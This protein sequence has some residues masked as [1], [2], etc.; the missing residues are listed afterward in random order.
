MDGP[1]A[2]W[3]GHR[4]DAS[5]I[6]LDPYAKAIGG[7]D[8][9]GEQP[10]WNDAYQHRGRLVYD[11]FDWESDHALETPI[12]DLIVYEMHVRSF[13]QHPSAG[14]NDPRNLATHPGQSA[15]LQELW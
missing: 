13:T 4:F 9:W 7:R 8:V 11:D 14:W 5:K 3:Q 2:Q 10:D 1:H 6:L 12:E 15:C